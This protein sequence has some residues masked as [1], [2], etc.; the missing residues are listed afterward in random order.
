LQNFTF[1]RP[2]NIDQGCRILSENRGK[3]RILAGGTY[4]IIEMRE[5]KLDPS[6]EM[7]M[8]ISHL[9]ELRFIEDDGKNIRIGAAATHA[10]VAES[11]LI[12]ENAPLLAE[13]S[14]TVGSPQIRNRGTLAGNSIT[15]SP[16]ADTIPPLLVLDATVVLRRGT[17]NREVPLRDIF[18]GPNQINIGDDELVTEIYFEKPPDDTRTAFIKLARRNSAAK[19]R[20]NFAAL[21]RQN[22]DGE[23]IELRISAGSVTPSP[24]RFTAAEDLLLG[25]IPAVN[26]L[27]EAGEAVSGEMI[28]QSGYRWS[29]DYK[30]PVVESLAERV[31]N[32]VLSL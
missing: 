27:K 2:K 20:M 30:K 32:Q 9:K 29:P 28:R 25:K 1:I 22:D 26:L 21:A 8:E 14:A 4:V 17:E 11:E 19:S 6:I 15:A 23:V 5:N 7:V 31:L 24:I 18:T 12:R 16:A 3:V 10:E 13:A